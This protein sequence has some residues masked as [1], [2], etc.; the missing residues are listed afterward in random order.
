MFSKRSKLNID[1]TN[2]YKEYRYMLF[3]YI[4]NHGPTFTR[5]LD[6]LTKEIVADCKVPGVKA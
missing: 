3:L 1:R 5:V 4:T 2:M 6:V